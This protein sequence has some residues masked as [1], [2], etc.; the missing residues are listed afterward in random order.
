MVMLTRRLRDAT[1]PRPYGESMPDRT[2]E[3]VSSADA[4]DL[5]ELANDADQLAFELLRV[6]EKLR[7]V[8][9]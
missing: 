9:T 4:D 6:A 3:H 2:L 7:P 5:A 8:D 1:K